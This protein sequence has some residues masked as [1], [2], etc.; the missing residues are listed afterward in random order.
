MTAAVAAI[1]EAPVRTISGRFIDSFPAG[2]C[3][4]DCARYR[5]A[6]VS[7]S[8]PISPASAFSLREEEAQPASAHVLHFTPVE[9]EL[10]KGGLEG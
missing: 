4:G 2:A 5:G 9:A 1:D 6:L 3:R 8:F 10:D 7:Y